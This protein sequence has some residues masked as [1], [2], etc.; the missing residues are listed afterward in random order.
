MDASLFFTKPKWL[1]DVRKVF[2]N[3]IDGRIFVNK[4]KTTISQKG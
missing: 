1:N 3:M 4:P 2:I